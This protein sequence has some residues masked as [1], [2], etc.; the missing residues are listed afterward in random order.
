MISLLLPRI[1]L[2]SLDESQ[3]RLAIS[4][5]EHLA[6]ELGCQMDAEAISEASQRAIRVKLERMEKAPP[7]TYPWYTY[8]LLILK[9]PQVGMGVAGFK[10]VP[11]KDGEVEIGYGISPAYQNH[12]YMSEAVQGLARWAFQQPGCASIRAE[13]L[14]SNVA[15]HRVLQKAGFTAFRETQVEIFWRIRKAPEMREPGDVNSLPAMSVDSPE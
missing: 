14:R 2:V 3:L 5:P 8:W 9:D 6:E 1:N 10:G 15:S 13:T 12:G 4:H 7:S 11:G